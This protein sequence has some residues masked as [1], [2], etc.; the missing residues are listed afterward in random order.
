MRWGVV[1]LLVPGIALAQEAPARMLGE[2]WTTAAGLN[3][4]AALQIT[5]LPP[6]RASPELIRRVMLNLDDFPAEKGPYPQT[7]LAGEQGG[8]IRLELTVSDTG[9][10]TACSIIRPSGVASLDAHACSH[11]LRHIRFHPALT[12]DGRRA[13]A[14]IEAYLRYSVIPWAPTV[15]PNHLNPPVWQKGRRASPETSPDTAMAE[16]LKGRILPPQIGSVGA[17]LRI[18]T[19]GRVSACT[20]YRPTLIDELDR[21]LC[22]RLTPIRFTAATNADGQAIASD[23]PVAALRP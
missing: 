7:A 21:S 5:L 22:E 12:R 14:T 16:V 13:G 9:V 3:R 19:D 15:G 11:V 17:M 2:K 6:G 10:P 4:R 23:Y 1:L 20:L 18:E 8:S